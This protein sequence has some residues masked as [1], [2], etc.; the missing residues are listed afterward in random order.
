MA[1]P[2][3][4]SVDAIARILDAQPR[5][6]LH[7][8]PSPVERLWR[9]ERS[10]NANVSLFIKRD[11]M[12]RPLCGNKIRYLEF[13]LGLYEQSGCDCLIHG[14]GLTSNYLAQLAMVGAARGIDVHLAISA[15]RPSTLQA[16]Q[17]IQGLCG[18]GLHFSEVDVSKASNVE[19]KMALAQQLREQGRKP[20]V[21]DYPLSNYTAYLGYMDC[22][23][24]ILLQSVEADTPFSHI[25]LCSGWHSYLGLRIAAD[26]VRPNLVI[27]GFRPA[28]REGTWL[29]REY[30]DFDLFL[31]DKV[32]EFAKFLGIP[33][34]TGAF[35]LSEDQVGPGYA[36]FDPRTFEAMRLLASTE[37]VLL[38]PVYTGKAF[39]G[40]LDRLARGFFPA[41]SSVLFIHTGGVANLFRFSE[42]LSHSFS[43][44]PVK[45]GSTATA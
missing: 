23:R 16:N 21:I 39:T 31:R 43:T 13:V 34:A 10:L 42:E 38:D 45:S 15:H 26:M 36:K 17:L 22:M 37:G 8:G 44:D 5:S 29:G 35:D 1:L 20:F 7:G 41:G 32:T 6:R 12:L 33:I 24:E 2:E 3:V 18:A 4:A 9:L 27:T 19:P 40:L 14:G 11:D 25:V 28:R 30:P